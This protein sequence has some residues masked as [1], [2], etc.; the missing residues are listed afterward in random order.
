MVPSADRRQ[1]QWEDAQ[2]AEPARPVTFRGMQIIGFGEP[3]S[4]L[5]RELVDLVLAGKKTATAG[6]LVELELD[7]EQLPTP[8]LR[9]VIIDADDQFVGE[10]ETTECRVM[11]MAD[12]DDQ[13]ARDE[14]EGFA[15]A[16]EWR[17]AHE[18]FW[19]R[20]LD[21]LRDRLGDPQWSLTDDTQVICQRFRLVS[22]YPEPI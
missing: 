2:M 21:E 17:L 1:R 6:L 19:N 5:R 11:R 12:V 8:G 7:G 16:A 10:I 13:F 14:G 3:R 20:Y 18:R 4:E 22:R 9:E 15:D